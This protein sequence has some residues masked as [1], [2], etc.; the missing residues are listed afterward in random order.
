[1]GSSVPGTTAAPAAMATRRAE[2]FEPILRIASG[3]G[4]MKTMPEAAHASANSG[5][6]AQE[7]VAGMDRFRLHAVA[8]L[9][10]ILSMRSNFP[11]TAMAPG[12]RAFVGE[13]HRQRGSIGVGIHRHAGDSQ[14][15][16]GPESADGDL[17]TI[18]N[19]HLGEHEGSIVA[20]D[21]PGKTL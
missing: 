14:A 17:S 8:L 1:M 16:A 11:M 20:V 6:L 19:Q 3:G 21:G 2:I 18:R 12:R 5:V 7:A 10:R 13:A 4:P 9:P 15:P